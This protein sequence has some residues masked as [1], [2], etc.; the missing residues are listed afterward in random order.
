MGNVNRQVQEREG[1]RETVTWCV[2]DVGG[3]TLGQWRTS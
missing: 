2:V 3:R 1:E